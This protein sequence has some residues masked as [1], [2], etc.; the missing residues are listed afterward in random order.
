LFIRGNV[1]TAPIYNRFIACLI[2]GDCFIRTTN[3]STACT[4]HPTFRICIKNM[5]IGKNKHQGQYTR[6][7]L[8]SAFCVNATYY[9]LFFHPEVLPHST[10]FYG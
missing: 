1:K 6:V 10:P 7:Q 5:R 9:T 8:T 4:D 3:N 2:N